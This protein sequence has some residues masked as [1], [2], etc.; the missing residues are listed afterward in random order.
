MKTIEYRAVLKSGQ[1]ILVEVQAPDLHAGFLV[2]LHSVL[3][4]VGDVGALDGPNEVNRIE[5]WQ[6]KS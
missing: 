6:V 2:A 3:R 5:F 1:E 4:S